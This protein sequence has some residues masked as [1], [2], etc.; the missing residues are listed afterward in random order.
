MHLFLI[1]ECLASIVI[2]KIHIHVID[3]MEL[4]AHYQTEKL[5]KELKFELNFYKKMHNIR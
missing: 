2:L 1:M 5:R 4:I 3:L